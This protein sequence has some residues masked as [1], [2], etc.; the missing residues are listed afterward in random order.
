MP[1][2]V[3]LS[4]YGFLLKNKHLAI[5]RNEQQI[6]NNVKIQITI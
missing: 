3:G 4:K 6:L 1:T 2:R 5:W